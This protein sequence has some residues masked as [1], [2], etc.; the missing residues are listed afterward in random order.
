MGPHPPRLLHF[1]L[2]PVAHPHRYSCAQNNVVSPHVESKIDESVMYEPLHKYF[3]ASSF[4]SCLMG[5]QLESQVSVA[6]VKQVRP[7]CR[8]LELEYNWKTRPSAWAA[9]RPTT[10]PGE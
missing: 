9:P 6:M 3:I 4:N 8:L 5:D 1:V 2:P 7:L 10:G